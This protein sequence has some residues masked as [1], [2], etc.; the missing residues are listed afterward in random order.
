MKAFQNLSYIY[1]IFIVRA[2]VLR[3][4]IIININDA[5]L[6][7]LAQTVILQLTKVVVLKI[8]IILYSGEYKIILNDIQTKV[9][10]IL[11]RALKTSLRHISHSP[12][13]L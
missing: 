1:D 5:F 9:F 2:F 12:N 10:S 4:R 8:K 7:L 11:P 6:T 3:A 13:F